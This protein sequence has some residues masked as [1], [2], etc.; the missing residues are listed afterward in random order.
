MTKKPLI[1]L[2]VPFFN[3]QENLGLLFKKITSFTNVRKQENYEVM[4]INDCSTDDGAILIKKLIKGHQNFYLI[5]LKKRSGQSGCFNYA[6]KKMKGD[7]FVRIDSDLQDDPQDLKQIVNELKKGR[8]LVLGIRKN[9]KH[10]LV[11]LKITQIY[12]FFIRYFFKIK[13]K[14]FSCSMLGVKKKFIARLNLKNT[15]HRFLPL[16]LVSV[17]GA[18]LFTVNVSHYERLFGKS[19]YNILRKLFFGIYEFIRVYLR[20]KKGDYSL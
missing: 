16:I 2:V 20:I 15:D 19:K 12:D 9:R 17:R 18:H 4:F 13:S 8:D 1:S 3:E 6:F 11:L 7:F 10:S 14:S 5:N